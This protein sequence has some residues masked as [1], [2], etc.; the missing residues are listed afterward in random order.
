MS[1]AE[2]MGLL[3]DLDARGRARSRRS[4]A[5]AG[6]A[7][8]RARSRDAR[9]GA[10]GVPRYPLRVLRA[11]PSTLPNTPEAPAVFGAIP[12]ATD[13]RAGSPARAGLGAGRRRDRAPG[14]QG[15][16]DVVL[17]PHLA[18]PAVR[19]RAALARR[20]QGGQERV[21]RHGQRRRR[22]A[23]RGGGAALADRARRAARRSRSWRR[24]RCPC[25]RASSSGT[26]GNRIL[27]MRAPLFTD[28]P[29]PVGG[30]SA[31]TPRCSR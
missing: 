24:S 25:A 21:R 9:R 28:E 10:L 31:R 18:A 17:R 23:L 12:G 6:S 29:D 8:T 13:G 1:G 16:A 20:G 7:P 5:G 22:R 30:S 2:I 15:A 4:A 14:A 3:L 19:V 26:Y 27:L 11:L